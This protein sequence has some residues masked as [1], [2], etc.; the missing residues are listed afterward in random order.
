MKTQI[1]TS[2]TI[3]PAPLTH[4]DIA[5]RA[6][7]LWQERGCPQG[8]DEKIWADAERQLRIEVD[9]LNTTERDIDE[10]LDDIDTP[11]VPSADKR[12]ITSL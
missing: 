11:Y 3:L 8:Q 10:E 4:E 12:S 1:K 7:A 5:K 9:D 2:R 6:Y